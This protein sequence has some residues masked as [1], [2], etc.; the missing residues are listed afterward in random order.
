MPLLDKDVE[1]A[2][3]PRGPSGLVAEGSLDRMN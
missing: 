3:I 1:R 2:E